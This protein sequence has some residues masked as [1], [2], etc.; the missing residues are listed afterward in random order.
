MTLTDYRA[1]RRWFLHQLLQVSVQ[2]EIGGLPKARAARERRHLQRRLRELRAEPITQ[3][4]PNGNPGR[5][6]RRQAVG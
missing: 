6:P 2:A 4:A 3:E 5:R 1:K